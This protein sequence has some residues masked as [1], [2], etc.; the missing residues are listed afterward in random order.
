MTCKLFENWLDRTEFWIQQSDMEKMAFTD[1]EKTLRPS[2]LKTAVIWTFAANAALEEIVDTWNEH[3][4]I[5]FFERQKA[6]VSKYDRY[7][8][9]ETYAESRE[10]GIAR[11]FG[12]NTPQDETEETRMWRPELDSKFI[13]AA[14]LQFCKIDGSPSHEDIDKAL[15]YLMYALLTHGESMANR[16]KD[17]FGMKALLLAQYERP[18][19]GS[20]KGMF[21]ALSCAKELCELRPTALGSD[22]LSRRGSRDRSALYHI[23][24]VP[25]HPERCS[26][27][28]RGLVSLSFTSPE[29]DGSM[30]ISGHG[31]F[32]EWGS[33]EISN[34]GGDSGIID[35][36]G[37]FHLFANFNARQ[38]G[39]DD[40]YDNGIDGWS[41]MFDAQASTWA[42]GGSIETIGMD[43]HE[44]RNRGSF[45]AVRSRLP[46][47][48]D[49]ASAELLIKQMAEEA[50]LKNPSGKPDWGSDDPDRDDITFPQ[51]VQ[52]VPLT[53]G[54]ALDP[55][56]SSERLEQIWNNDVSQDPAQFEVTESKVKLEAPIQRGEDETDYKFEL[57]R[58]ILISTILLQNTFRK[59]FIN[60]H[61]DELMTDISSF[62]ES[63]G[64][65]DIEIYRKWADYLWFTPLM[66]QNCLGQ[67]LSL[68]NT[69]HHLLAEIMQE[70]ADR[71]EQAQVAANEI[72]V[73]DRLIEENDEEIYEF[74]D[75]GLKSALAGN[76]KRRKNNSSS[77]GINLY[78]VGSI[79]AT[80][81]SVAGALLF[82]Y[83]VQR[84]RN[85]NPGQ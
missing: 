64:V 71:Q 34:E 1:E 60:A 19:S 69:I 61:I 46:E 68:T 63:G 10:T 54:V 2:D 55:S 80:I 77:S 67:R 37:A 14:A 4:P 51:L 25:I 74:D 38:A 16:L 81:V 73:D 79:A 78:V 45:V 84:R 11:V 72:D 40:D 52:W 3:G 28:I 56:S 70:D 29:V 27:V 50:F 57:R 65:R 17:E 7:L 42:I 49:E 26:K 48:Q 82:G 32:E 20:Y 47:L 13:T 44:R 6:I 9:Q 39:G 85:S 58:K 59:L 22:G 35:A 53:L 23:F 12:N 75:V 18:L 24:V 43:I 66:Q 76:S 8:H 41:L 30:F 36:N 21:T 83:M 5:G 62:N 31:A 15:D 33:F